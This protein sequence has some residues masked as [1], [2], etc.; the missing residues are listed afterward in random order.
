MFLAEGKLRC[1]R[2]T[3]DVEVFARAV[4]CVAMRRLTA[5]D[6]QLWRPRQDP[7]IP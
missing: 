7:E 5:R 6:L 2:L 3:V 4:R 1:M